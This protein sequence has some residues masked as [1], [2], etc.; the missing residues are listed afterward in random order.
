MEGKFH[1][2]DIFEMLSQMIN[3]KIR[4]HKSKND[5]NSSEED[6]KSLEARL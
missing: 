4:Y 5:M 6:M 2:E 1:Y 3:L